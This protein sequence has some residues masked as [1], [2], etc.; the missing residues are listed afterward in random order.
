MKINDIIALF[1][2]EKLVEKINEQK[3]KQSQTKATIKSNVKWK[4]KNNIVSKDKLVLLVRVG[5]F[6]YTF[7][8]NFNVCFCGW[9]RLFLI[10]VHVWSFGWCLNQV[11]VL[12]AQTWAE[13]VYLFFAFYFSHLNITW[14]CKVFENFEINVWS[15]S[16]WYLTIFHIH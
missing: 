3:R 4:G 2:I 13:S 15:E 16:N 5:V 8:F 14:I 1:V 6:S 10:S 9:S 11:N 7:R 12:D